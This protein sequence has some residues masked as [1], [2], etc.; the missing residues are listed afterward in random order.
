MPTYI[1]RIP[2]AQHPI[3]IVTLKDIVQALPA[4]IPYDVSVSIYGKIT[5]YG[6]SAEN[7]IFYIDSEEEPSMEMMQYFDSLVQGLGKQATAM[8]MRRGSERLMMRIYNEGRLI[9]DKETLAFT[10]LPSKTKLSPVLTG[11][12]VR[13]KLPSTFPWNYK[14]Y[15]TGGI[16]K[17]S[18]SAN[19]GDIIIFEPE[20]K[21]DLPA[22]RKWFLETMSWRF[23]VGQQVMYEREPVYLCKI[24]DNGNKCD[25]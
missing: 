7:I 20:A 10:E 9:V 14:V 24:Y 8:K 22:I 4:Q 21:A 15:L 2:Q 13:A 17:H 3:V 18:W 1:D 6:Q 25:F 12:E 16:A 5:I 23:D 11:D 19:D